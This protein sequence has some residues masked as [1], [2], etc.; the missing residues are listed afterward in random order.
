M[1]NGTWKM[2]NPNVQPLF[3]IYHLPFSIQAVV[4]QRPAKRSDQR[5]VF[6][7][8]CRRDEPSAR[9]VALF[10]LPSSI[11]HSGRRVSAAC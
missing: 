1:V 6:V 7:P 3:S 11:F 10:H 5:R 2:E 8:S 9:S 4:F